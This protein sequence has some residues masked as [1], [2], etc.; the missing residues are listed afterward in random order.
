M[1]EHHKWE[2]EGWGAATAQ[3]REAVEFLLRG[4]AGSDREFISEEL[5]ALVRSVARGDRPEAKTSPF[6]R[7]EH[8][9]EGWARMVAGHIVGG[10]MAAAERST[11]GDQDCLLREIIRLAL[12][13]MPDSVDEARKAVKYLEIETLKQS[14][15]RDTPAPEI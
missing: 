13:H 11:K 1:P 14:H 15:P 6:D 8:A 4:K 12:W 10:A 2:I 5:V 9:R 7:E 3:I